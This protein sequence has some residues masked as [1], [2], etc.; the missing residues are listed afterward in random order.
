MCEVSIVKHNVL[1]ACVMH[2]PNVLT[3]SRS[4]PV[5]HLIHESLHGTAHRVRAVC[6]HLAVWTWQLRRRV[7]IPDGA[8]SM[9][10][11]L[12]IY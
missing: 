1:L 12:S 7:L 5:R 10:A 9:S 11:T 3:I 4:V 6:A 8:A 2:H